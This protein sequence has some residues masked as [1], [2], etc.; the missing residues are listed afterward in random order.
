MQTSEDTGKGSEKQGDAL[1]D[2][3]FFLV[4]LKKRR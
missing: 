1:Y 3:R 2:Q 4:I